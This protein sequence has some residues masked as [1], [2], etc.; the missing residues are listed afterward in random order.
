[1]KI[2]SHV[3]IVFPPED[4]FLACT[5]GWMGIQLEGKVISA[6]IAANLEAF[7]SSPPHLPNILRPN[8][9][10]KFLTH[11]HKVWQCYKHK[12]SN[13]LT[14][15]THKS[16]PHHQNIRNARCSEMCKVYIRQLVAVLVYFFLG[17]IFTPGPWLRGWYQPIRRI[18][19][20]RKSNTS[21]IISMSQ[22][23]CFK[24]S[25]SPNRCIKLSMSQS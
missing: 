15:T 7:Q 1:M 2:F 23:R 11:F 10:L 20:V 22:Q 13:F 14:R 6:T 24:L 9:K 8:E 3:Q 12:N 18:V 16:V 5:Q 25:M 4:H 21:S 19:L 17:Q